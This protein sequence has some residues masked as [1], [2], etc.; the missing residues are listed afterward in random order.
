MVKKNRDVLD[1]K[2][3]KQKTIEELK[4]FESKKLEADV[5]LQEKLSNFSNELSE[6]EGN[7]L[8]EL[9]GDSF[10]SENELEGS[11]PDVSIYLKPQQAHLG[12]EVAVF[13]KPQQ[14]HMNQDVAV[15]LKPQQAHSGTQV[16]VR[17]GSQIKDGDEYLKPQQAHSVEKD[18]HLKPQQSHVNS[19]KNSDD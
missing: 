7:I 15:F 12:E 6:L 14:S 8:S 10:F 4:D 3:A 17:F 11:N 13:L 5:T 9:L 1:S 18:V 2:I 19:D 16:T